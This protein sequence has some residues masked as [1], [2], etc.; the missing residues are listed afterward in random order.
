MEK[1]LSEIEA[2]WNKREIQ[3]NPH[4]GYT[5]SVFDWVVDITALPTSDGIRPMMV[6]CIDE[7]RK[8]E[9]ICNRMTGQEGPVYLSKTNC[10]Q[11]THA[12]VFNHLV[13]GAM[14]KGIKQSKSSD[15]ANSWT[16]NKFILSDNKLTLT[17]GREVVWAPI[18]GF[19]DDA[20][21]FALC[22]V[23]EKPYYTE[24]KIYRTIST[25]D[26]YRHRHLDSSDWNDLGDKASYILTDSKLLE[27][28]FFVKVT[29]EDF[30]KQKISPNH[31]T[32]KKG[33]EYWAIGRSLNPYLVTNE[34]SQYDLELISKGLYYR[35]Y[36]TAIKVSE[37]AR[38]AADEALEKLKN[39]I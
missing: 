2:L 36:D 4:L 39:Q 10:R 7:S 25:R 5:P 15:D 35:D 20:T 26:L 8:Q 19:L 32:P 37:C 33:E 34:E 38:K 30:N 1:S 27:N 28:G 6:T 12:E 31:W 16:D 9:L 24:G 14:L 3:N 23:E 17:L 13:A 22:L 21:G 18:Y 11:A 29:E